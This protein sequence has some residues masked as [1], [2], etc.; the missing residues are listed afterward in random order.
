VAISG[1]T[2]VVG[3]PSQPVFDHSKYNDFQGAAYVFVKPASGWADMTPTA[4]LTASDGAPGDFMGGSVGISSNTIV[5][6]ANQ[7]DS[8][9]QGAAYVFVKP[10]DGW[11][12][13]SQTAELTAS[14]GA[15]GSFFGFSVSIS[16]HTVV[17]GA[18]DAWVNGRYQGAAYVFEKPD[19]GWANMTQTAKLTASNAS[20]TSNF[21]FSVSISGDTAV[22]GD[23]DE[24][25]GGNQNQG[26]A[27]VFVR[28]TSGWRDMTQTAELTVSYVKANVSHLPRTTQRSRNLTPDN[29]GWSVF[30]KGNSVVAGAPGHSDGSGAAYVFLKP[31]GG[32]KPTS[33]S[34]ASLTAKN[35]KRGDAFGQS[36][37]IT[38]STVLV[39]AYLATVGHN[40]Q[41]AAYVFRPVDNLFANDLNHLL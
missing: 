35:G 17:V 21:G 29:L 4:R 13:M 10:S 24:A 25:V 15:W 16:R 30:I 22:I 36:V 37:C 11:R 3:A 27:Y 32:W 12:D 5:V 18:D 2:I 19:A 9:G 6:G 28:P 33:K 40:S 41:G 38:G 26:S 31:P 8:G 39:G 1:N 23:P 34:D 7:I 14:D 20:I